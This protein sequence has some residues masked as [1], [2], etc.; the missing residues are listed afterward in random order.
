[1]SEAIDVYAV[2][3]A[4]GG[5]T[6]LWPLSRR[7]LPKPF[8]PLL[9]QGSLLQATFARLSTLV[10]PQDVYVVTDHRFEEMVR[11]QLPAL[12]KANVVAEPRSRNTAAAI[13]LAGVAI[14]RPHDQ[15][16]AVLAADHAVKDAAGLRTALRRAEE[17]ARGGDLVTLGITPSG[18]ETGYGYVIAAAGQD[19]LRDPGAP[20]RV[21]RFVEK[22]SPERAR[23]LLATRRAYWNASIFIW[24]RDAL[25]DELARHAPGILDPI[26]RAVDAG[27]DLATAYAAVEARQ[28]DHALMEPASLEGRVAVVPTDVG[29]SDLG[30][31]AALEEALAAA[32]PEPKVVLRAVP[33]AQAIDQGSQRILV[34]ASSG[35]LVATVGLQDVV[36]VDTPDALLVVS[37]DHAQEVRRIV[38][39]LA[40]RG[41]DDLL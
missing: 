35:R 34:V 32:A 5:G 40:A 39:E 20:R 4:G 24:R 22:P 3:L 16:M 33:G 7:G 26:R 21:E 36:V 18:P 8:L 9:D 41:A 37:A 38:D 27:P 12:P 30:S 14:E 31:W 28:I 10:E 29:W 6:R 15:V 25:L 11:D 2:I 23:E 19:E 1:M 17:Q 13:A